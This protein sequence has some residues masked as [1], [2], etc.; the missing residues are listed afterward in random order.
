M[1]RRKPQPTT[2]YSKLDELLASD[3]QPMPERNRTHQ[4]R[5]MADAL[6]ELMH[7]PQ[8]GTNA[9]RVVSKAEFDG[10]EMPGFENHR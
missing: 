10:N 6:H 7:A 2:V 4:L 5:R 8:P 3:T 9:W 1:K